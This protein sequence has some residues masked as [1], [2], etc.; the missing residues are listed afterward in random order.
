VH[1]EAIHK[2]DDL[3]NEQNANEE[4]SASG[5]ITSRTWWSVGLA[6]SVIAFGFA[7]GWV[8]IR[9][10]V[11]PLL[12][13]ADSLRQVAKTDLNVV[14]TRMRANAE[15]TWNQ[16]TL[17]SGAAE[18]V[19]ANAQ[20]LATAVEQFEASIKEISGNASSAAAVARTAVN[21]AEETNTTITKLGQSSVEIGNVI[22]VINSI[23][24]QTNLVALNA[25]IEAARAGEAGKSP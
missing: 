8:I 17:A 7:F 21:A 14:S 15:E 4:T 18:K 22:K 11:H 20:A 2:V 13:F 3:A 5:I 23:A 19:S 12:R 10:T 16:A 24:E 6:V 25:T 1:H 9:E